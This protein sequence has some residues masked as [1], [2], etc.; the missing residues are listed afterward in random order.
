L[1]SFFYHI[2]PICLVSSILLSARLLKLGDPLFY[3]RGFC[4]ELFQVFLQ[5]G[6]DLFLADE[7]PLSKPRPKATSVMTPAATIT[8]AA[9]IRHVHDPSPALRPDHVARDHIQSRDTF[10]SSFLL[11]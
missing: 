2:Y 9:T 10:Y 3:S 5:T 1:P 6:D 4:P 8:D 7:A 11:Q